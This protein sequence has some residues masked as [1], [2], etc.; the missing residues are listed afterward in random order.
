MNRTSPGNGKRRAGYHVDEA[1]DPYYMS[2]EDKKILKEEVFSYWEGR[3]AQ[4][5]FYANI[6]EKDTKLLTQTSIVSA[7]HSETGVGECVPDTGHYLFV[8]GFRGIQEEAEEKLRTWTD[9]TDSL[10][11]SRNFM[12][13]S[14]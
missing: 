2:K 13:P 4:D 14:S 10:I 6:D 9:M 1:S 8:K 7:V 11:Q 12:K 5:C 3:S